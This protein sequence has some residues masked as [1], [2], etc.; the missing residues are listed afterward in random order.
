MQWTHLRSRIETIAYLDSLNSFYQF[1]KERIKNL[2]FNVKALD[3]HTNL[4]AI[5]KS[6]DQSC[7]Y[8]LCKNCVF[9]NYHWVASSELKAHP[10]YSLRGNTHD[11]FSSFCLASKSNFCDLWVR[12]QFLAHG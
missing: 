11:A 5:S 8:R 4:S 3:A 7:I 12:N 1:L 9:A 10:L 2:R 6:I